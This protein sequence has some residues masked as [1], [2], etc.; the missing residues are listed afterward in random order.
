MIQSGTAPQRSQQ[1]EIPLV[2]F[3]IWL[4]EDRGLGL[5]GVRFAGYNLGHLPD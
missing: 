2:S 5:E 1:M 4:Q 3:N